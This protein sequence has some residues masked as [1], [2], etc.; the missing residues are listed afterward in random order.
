MH[1]G[2]FPYASSFYMDSKRRINT[3]MRS[4]I[5]DS[6]EIELTTKCTL[7]C[8]GCSRVNTKHLKEEWDKG[9]LPLD[10]VLDTIRNTNFKSYLLIGCYGDSIYYPHFW[11]VMKVLV[12]EG[13]DWMVHTNGSSRSRDWWLQSYDIKFKNHRSNKFYFA[14]DGLEDTNHNYRINSKW[15]TIET[16]LD[17]MTN[18]PNR[19]KLYWRW[20]DFA[21]N[22]HQQDEARKFAESMDIEFEIY[23]SFRIKD[24]Y[25]HDNPEIFTA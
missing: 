19:P 14:I 21:Y 15:K 10:L 23:E 20:L 11:E 18:H 7:A 22:R 12:E 6:L 1:G 25:K 9:H 3:T 4:M 8:P 16:A 5:L 2:L 17:V 24:Q 13:K